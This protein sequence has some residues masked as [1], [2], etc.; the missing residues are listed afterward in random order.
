RVGDRLHRLLLAH[1]PG[2]QALLHVQELLLF[3]FQHAGH[4]DAAPFG[5]HF[6][7]V[8]GVHLFL[9]H[10]PFLLQVCQLLGFGFQILLQ[11]EQR[12]IFQ[13]RGPG[14]VADTFR[15]GGVELGLLDLLL[16]GADVADDFLF[17]LPAGLEG[18]ASLPEVGQA[19]VDLEQALLGGRVLLL[20]QGLPFD[21]LLGDFALHLVNVRRAGIDLHTQLGG[22]LIDQ[23]YRL[24][25]QVPVGEVALG[26][27]GRGYDGAV[28]D[29]HPVVHLVFFLQAPEDGDGILHRGLAHHDGL[30]AALQGRVLLDVFAVFVDGGGPD[31]MELTPGQGRLD[32]VGGVHRAFGGAGAHQGME[33]VDEHDDLAFGLG[34]LLEHRLQAVF[35]FAPELGAG[36]QGA[37]VQGHQALVLQALG[38]V[39]VDDALGQAFHDGRLAHPGLADE[40]RVVLGAPGQYLDDAPD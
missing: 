18:G 11:V 27:G 33:L 2:R 36:D 8:F 26:E 32:H 28:L 34:H 19:L 31:A 10:G 29:A 6:G 3:A 17:L 24:V 38:D 22:R 23:I 9:E 39:A 30:E 21:L 7:D 25:R 15:L 12:P 16:D 4:R 40:H 35:E 5:D 20:A 13:L 14:Q 37:Q 1:H